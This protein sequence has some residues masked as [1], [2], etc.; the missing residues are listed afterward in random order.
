M[1][2]HRARTVTSVLEFGRM[3]AGHS[4]GVLDAVATQV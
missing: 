4:V 2:M 3:N 1:L